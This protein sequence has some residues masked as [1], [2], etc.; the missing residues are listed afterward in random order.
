MLKNQFKP[1]LSGGII[2]LTMYSMTKVNSQIMKNMVNGIMSIM[3]VK[4]KDTN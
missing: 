2:P 4:N 1:S 3:H